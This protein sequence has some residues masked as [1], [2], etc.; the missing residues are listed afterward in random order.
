M[1]HMLHDE[2]KVAVRL[3]SSGTVA[4]MRQLVACTALLLSVQVHA[5][6]SSRRV[7]QPEQQACR[8]VLVY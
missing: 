7:P 2:M 1:K 8:C 4:Y 3:I 5:A 6:Y